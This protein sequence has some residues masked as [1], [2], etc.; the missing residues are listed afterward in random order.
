MGKVYTLMLPPQLVLKSHCIY[1]E[2]KD[3]D[4]SISKSRRECR[5]VKP[6]SNYPRDEKIKMFLEAGNKVH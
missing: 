1:K 4:L 6:R 5:Q 3:I 2:S